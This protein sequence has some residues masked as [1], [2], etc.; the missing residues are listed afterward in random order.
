MEGGKYNIEEAIFWRDS[1]RQGWPKRWAQ[2]CRKL[3]GK[4]RFVYFVQAGQR[5][6]LPSF[7]HNLGPT[8]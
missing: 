8:F 2:G 4:L 6:F 1:F 3:G 5:N 7:S